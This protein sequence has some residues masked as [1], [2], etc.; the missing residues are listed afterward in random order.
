MGQ[1]CS[2]ATEFRWRGLLRRAKRNTTVRLR[3]A[4]TFYLD[5]VQKYGLPPA[6]NNG[7]TGPTR[8][9]ST[10]F[11][12]LLPHFLLPHYWGPGGV[13]IFV[14]CLNCAICAARPARR[15]TMSLPRFGEGL[16]RRFNAP[17]GRRFQA[18]RDAGANFGDLLR[19]Q[20]IR[21]IHEV[22]VSQPFSNQFFR[23]AVR[24]F[25]QTFR[26]FKQAIF[27]FGRKRNSHCWFPSA[28]LY[29]VKKI[30]CA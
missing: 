20:V 12:L 9:P 19:R 16:C 27:N 25:T 17:C 13:R 10:R 3:P 21:V 26:V 4:Q 14:Q 29:L 1:I 2:I 28:Q 11:L 30:E 18:T 23:Q 15:K 6:P 24:I 8:K 7:G 5:T 22:A